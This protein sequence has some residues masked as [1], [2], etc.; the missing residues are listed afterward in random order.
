M[1][2]KYR[3]PK[4]AKYGVCA[5]RDVTAV[6]VGLADVRAVLLPVADYRQGS[7]TWSDGIGE[8]ETGIEPVYRA[9][10]ARML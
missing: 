10:Q 1:D 9:L 5:S 3:Q 7:F 4:P 2:L 6:E 8:A